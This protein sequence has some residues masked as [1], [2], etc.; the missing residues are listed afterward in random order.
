M[1][2][3]I[4]AKTF[5]L[6]EYAALLGA[7]AIIITTTPC[8]EVSLID[9]PQ[10]VGIHHDA[11]AGR[12]W[13]DHVKQGLQFDDPYQGRGGLGA[14]SAQFL[15]AYWAYTSLWNVSE[16]QNAYAHYASTGQGLQP[17]G[18]DVLAQ[19][20]QACVFI[21]KNKN[22]I[23]SFPW[24]FEDLSFIL[25]HTG[26]KLA[27]HHHL[28]ETHLPSNMNNLTSTVEKAH[29]AFKEKK[30]NI[31]IE[32]VNTYYQQLHALNLVAPS[33]TAQINQLH[34]QHPEIL[35]LKGCGAMGVDIL[36]LLTLKTNKAS[37]K[38]KLLAQGHRIVATEEN[39][40]LK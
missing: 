24:P 25:V 4:P 6:G 23:N 40:Y 2:W 7:P 33:T 22:I 16:L 13:R 20:Q 27:T 15:G 26:I 10:L 3:Y 34:T 1:K 9:T 39:L 17:S 19:S 37:L 28:Q 11:P 31:L 5:L 14:S 18:Y 21:H 38:E 29:L 32:A 30:S 36:L 12:F 35:A 8:F